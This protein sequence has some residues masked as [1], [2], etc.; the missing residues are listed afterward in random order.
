MFWR[1]VRRLLIANRSRLF[2]ILLAL[3]AGAAVTSA[4]L[5]LQIDARR[6]LSTEFRTFGT[7]VMVAPRAATAAENATMSEDVLQQLPAAADSQGASAVAF[8]YLLG[9]VSRYSL[10]QNFTQVVVAGTSAGTC[11]AGAR[12][13]E[14][15]HLQ[16]QDDVWVANQDRKEA[17][18][19]SAIAST[20]GPEDD[21]MVIPL[22]AAQRLAGL[23]GRVSLIQISV[24]A[25]PPAMNDYI[26]ALTRRLPGADVHG[27]RQFTEAEAKI[28][29]RISGLLNATVV[30]VLILTT[31]CV[32]AAMTNVA[33][34]RKNDVGL[35]K[36]IGG[37]TRRVL[38]L[39]LAEAA[40]L[41]LLG[42]IVGA[43]AGIVLSIGLG[44]AVFGVA[45]KPRLI[46]YPV[47]V[48]LT[49]LVAIASAYPLRRLA[50][51]RPASVF[52]GE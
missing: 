35:M 46:V 34:E 38:R 49:V 51:I 32:M 39:F 6:R 26:A 27:I 3:S 30:V 10:P 16:V 36:A 2:V 41:G 25:T 45:A 13:A 4:L 15:M 50:S 9:G 23:P 24:A 20:G 47:A 5:N 21:Q 1:I 11:T 18:R 31:L 14:R 22:A 43:A 37:A 28:Y 52:R 19:L 33:M 40:V 29:D 12:L 8:L 44:K 7:N 42:G 48:T 17:C